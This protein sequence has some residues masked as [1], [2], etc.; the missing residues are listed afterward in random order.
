MSSPSY[1]LIVHP[2]QVQLNSTPEN[3]QALPNLVIL[4]RLGS[5]IKRTQTVIAVN[6]LDAVWTDELRMNR[7]NEE[8]LE[9]R[10]SALETPTSSQGQLLG[11]ATIP[12]SLIQQ[13]QILHDWFPLIIKGENEA[14]HVLVQI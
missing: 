12:F 7:T 1:N 13:S 8:V 2:V 14:G 11:V 4:V 10:L 3:L 9:V 5:Q 6:N